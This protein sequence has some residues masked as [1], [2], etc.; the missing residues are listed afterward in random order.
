M[1]RAWR[2]Q[3]QSGDLLSIVIALLGPHSHSHGTHRETEKEKR[4]RPHPFGFLHL[5]P[6]Y[7]EL[8]VCSAVSIVADMVVFALLIINKAGAYTHS[9]SNRQP[10]AP[11]NTA[12]A[13]WSTIALLLL[14]C[15]S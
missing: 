15:R 2:S 13:A 4:E 3:A 8:T 11:F 9:L 7:E 1:E 6:L 10:C 12:Q 5:D 14:D